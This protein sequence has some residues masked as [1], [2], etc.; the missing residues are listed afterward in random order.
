M[1]RVSKGKS[2]IV[3]LARAQPV[4]VVIAAQSG[5]PRIQYNGRIAYRSDGISC[6]QSIALKA[7]TH[8]PPP[9]HEL[10]ATSSCGNGYLTDITVHATHMH[11]KGR[12]DAAEHTPFTMT[13]IPCS[14]YKVCATY[15][16]TVQRRLLDIT[17]SA[18]AHALFMWPME[19]AGRPL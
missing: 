16:G 12:A 8:E 6:V 11:D 1:N 19:A 18:H 7:V 15:Q 10:V 14:Q 3:A 17:S 2:G 5:I 4:S 9:G 13:S